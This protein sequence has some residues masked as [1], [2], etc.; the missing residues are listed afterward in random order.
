MN[1][2]IIGSGTVGQTLGGK[3]AALGHD[4]KIGTRDPQKLTDW[5]AKVGQKASVGS[6]A[7]A[8]AWG[9]IVFNC[10]TGAASLAALTQA[11]EQNLSGK[12][13]VDVANPL[14]FSQGMPPTL[15]VC[16]T[17]SLAEQIQRAF[18]Q[19]RVVKTL[20][21]MNA[22]LMV[23]PA[24]LPGEHDVFVSGNDA[25]AKAAVTAILTDMFGWRSVIDLGDIKTARTVEMLLPLW[26]NLY[27]VFQTATFN[28]KIIR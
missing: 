23:N 7:E 8:A 21:T 26:V 11:G 10:T 12:T 4:V 14:D 24:L 18:P 9:E 28:F 25:D 20:N 5:Q 6:F 19:A 27:G 3:L 1:I 17:D 13:L 15:T 22:D 16:N 2:G